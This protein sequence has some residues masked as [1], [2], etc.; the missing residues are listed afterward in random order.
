MEYENKQSK[1]CNYNKSLL[2]SPFLKG[3]E[4]ARLKPCPTK[5]PPYPCFGK[6]GNKMG[7]FDLIKVHY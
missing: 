7:D 2:N 4:K 6:G 5:N 1:L 3:R